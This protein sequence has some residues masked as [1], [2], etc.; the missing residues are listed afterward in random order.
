VANIPQETTV[1][2]VAKIKIYNKMDLRQVRWKD[3]NLIHLNQDREKWKV[4]LNAIMNIWA[5]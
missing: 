4:I 2:S 1:P 5:P 3:V